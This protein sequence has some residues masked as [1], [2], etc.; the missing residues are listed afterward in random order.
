MKEI[1]SYMGGLGNRLFQ[2][3]FL[4]SQ[5]KQGTL[6]DI[7]LQDYRYFDEYK[8]ELRKILFEGVKGTE[9]ISLHIRRGDYV[10]NPYYTDLTTTDYYQKAV[11]EFPNEKFLV[12]CADRQDGSNDAWDRQWCINL[13]KAF[14]PEERFDIHEGKD[15][16]E[17]WNAQAG[18]KG[19]IMAN[20]SFSF[21]SAYIGGGKTIAPK[22][23]FGD[24]HT[25]P[26]PEEFILL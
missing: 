21:W 13:L 11:N 12:F 26:L 1:R 6:P 20:S 22:Q 2:F 19:H 23:W 18:C 25:I 5:V 15:E 7:Y 17:D 14:L 10:N 16:I 3:A 4:Y 9:Y 24:G 8:S